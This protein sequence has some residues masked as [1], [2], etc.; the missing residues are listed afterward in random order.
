MTTSNDET[1]QGKSLWGKLAIPLILGIVVAVGY[2]QFGSTLSLES[3]ADREEQLRSLQNQYPALVFGSAF[4]I[5]VAI[6]GMSLP[7]A[8]ALTLT[9]GWYFGFLQ[10]VVLVSFASTLGATIAFLLSRYLFRD[11]II[12]R[13]GDRL[14]NFN[15]ALEKEGPFYL[16]TLRLIPAVPFFVVNAVMGLTPLKTRTFWWVSQLGMLAG[17]AV[18][19][20]AGSSVPNLSDLAENGVNAAFS[21]TQMFQIISAFVLLGAFPLVA[22]WTIKMFWTDSSDAASLAT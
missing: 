8:A 1:R 20:Y 11:T 17:T 4:L 18:Y 15:E 5:Y 19:V 14:K 13:F 9:Y 12:N 21:P 3:L 6:T 16:F 22:R 10:G 7:G 2:W